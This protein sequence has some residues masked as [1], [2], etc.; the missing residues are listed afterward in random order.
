[1]TLIW[2]I[3]P[4][5]VDDAEAAARL[6]AESVRILAAG[7]YDQRQIDVWSASLTAGALE[8]RM[9]EMPFVVAEADGRICGFAAVNLS[10]QE[11]EYVYVHPEFAGRG[12]GAALLAA[13]EDLACRH[14]HRQVFLVSSLNAAEFYRRHGYE[15]QQR[16]CRCREGV[17]IPCLRMI[18]TLEA[19][20]LRNQNEPS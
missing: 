2:Q 19:P 6:A 20:R 9:R 14:G 7:S 3:R 5:S 17:D 18:K 10:S 15:E 13:A 1:M 4:A 16:L 12:L 8:N 11:V